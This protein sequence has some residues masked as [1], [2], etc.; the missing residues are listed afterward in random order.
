MS[1]ASVTTGLQLIAGMD[2]RW[3][4]DD[5]PWVLDFVQGDR[6]IISRPF[7]YSSQ[8]DFDQTLFHLSKQNVPISELYVE[9]EVRTT[10][11]VRMT[12]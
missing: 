9:R 1:I 8:H 11:K 3:D 5:G 6:A 10:E 4:R 12:S 2:V 7:W